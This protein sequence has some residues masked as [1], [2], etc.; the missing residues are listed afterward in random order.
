M[1]RRVRIVGL[2]VGLPALAVAC[3]DDELPF[4]D[5]W[6]GEYTAVACAAMFDNECDCAFAPPW[7][8]AEVCEQ[9]NAAGVRRVQV[10]AINAGLVFDA[11]CAEDHVRA[12]ETL[13]CRL[14][15]ELDGESGTPSCQIYYGDKQLGDACTS[16]L[17]NYSSYRGFWMSDCEQDLICPTLGSR[18]TTPD[19]PYVELAEGAA[20][21]DDDGRAAGLCP[22]P[23]SCNLGSKLC[24]IPAAV[25]EPCPDDYP[26]ADA[27]CDAGTCAARKPVDAAC[28][29]SPECASF[30]CDDNVC[31][32]TGPS[33]AVCFALML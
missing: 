8:S 1:G 25:G 23:Q 12:I 16:F 31:V 32:A 27:W 28:E 24:V 9:Q 13:D 19:Q 7:S 14:L 18:C 22:E 10:D 29:A 26:C 6:S 15:D 17:W 30:F 4:E 33:A 11:A 2:A 21:V 20:C 3:K 5:R